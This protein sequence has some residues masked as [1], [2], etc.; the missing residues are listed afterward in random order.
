M[1]ENTLSKKIQ[2][3][4]NQNPK[5]IFILSFSIFIIGAAI[6]IFF[7]ILNQLHDRKISVT[8]IDS[9]VKDMPESKKQEIYQT[10]YQAA[11]TNSDLGETT[12]STATATIR[13][14][15]F[16]ESYD[17]YNYIHSGEFIVDIESIKQTY[18]IYYDWS[19]NKD[20]EQLIASSYGVT[21]NCPSKTEAIYD[22]YKCKNPYTDENYRAYDYLTMLLPYSSNLS[23]GTPFSASPVDYYYGS[24]EPF[25][26][27]SVDAC[28]DNKKVDNGVKAFK[29]Y[30]KNYDLNPDDYN[31]ISQNNC[32]G[33]DL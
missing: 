11:E 20:S 31:I 21:A 22:F 18:H 2:S 33:G 26:R 28:G 8:N 14:K 17:S 5:L 15:T 13:E 16:S 27:I 32:D 29:D 9:Y 6:I 30:L 1:E 19:P 3:K 24:N 12:L 25:V 7:A 4:I 10:I 23:D